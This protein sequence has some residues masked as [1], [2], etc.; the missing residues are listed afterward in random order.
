MARAAGD[1]R[2]DSAIM[3]S[4]SSR[5]RPMTAPLHTCRTRS[6]SSRS[7]VRKYSITRLVSSL[8]IAIR[9]LLNRT[10]RIRSRFRKNLHIYLGQKRLAVILRGLDHFTDLIPV[11]LQ[12]YRRI[13][14]MEE[15][16]VNLHFLSS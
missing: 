3:A 16:I 4:S 13:S 12:E 14:G 9:T 11:N 10:D 5:W 2:S 1:G 15:D 8:R 7:S 6:A